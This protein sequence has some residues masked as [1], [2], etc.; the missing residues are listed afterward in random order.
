[1]PIHTIFIHV[2]RAV[3]DTVPSKSTR[4]RQAEMR[5]YLSVT[6]F[7]LLFCCWFHSSW[8]YVLPDVCYSWIST[9]LHP[10]ILQL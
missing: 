9:I 2:V 3:T 8:L 10:I 5:K 4:R 7:L 6:V 1:M